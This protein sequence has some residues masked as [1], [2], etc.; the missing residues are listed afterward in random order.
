[1]PCNEP[2]DQAIERAARA[3][4]NDLRGDAALW[5]MYRKTA[6]AALTAALPGSDSRG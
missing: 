1:M 2:D 6:A 5:R 3:I 4:A